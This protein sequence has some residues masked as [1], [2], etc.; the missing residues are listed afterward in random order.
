MA[1]VHRPISQ[2]STAFRKGSKWSER[3]HGSRSVCPPGTGATQGSHRQLPLAQPAGTDQCWWRV[4]PRKLRGAGLVHG[5]PVGCVLWH[6]ANAEE[7][8]SLALAPCPIGHP[9]D[10][11]HDMERTLLDMYEPG[12]STQP[13]RAP[14]GHI[15]P[16]NGADVQDIGVWH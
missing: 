13:Y 2:S 8:E 6:G 4:L 12:T 16:C 1:V 3:S 7:L 15:L 10:Q 14:I 5:V 9:L 11:Q